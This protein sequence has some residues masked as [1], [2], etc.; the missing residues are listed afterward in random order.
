MGRRGTPLLEPDEVIAILLRLGFKLDRQNGS[1]AQYKRAAMDGRAAA[2]VTV[3]VHYKVFDVDLM[4]SMIRQ[5]GFSANEF[6]GA[7]KG[8]ARKASVPYAK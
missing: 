8:S 3:D 4:K 5:S 7:T 2:I 1:H 6:Y